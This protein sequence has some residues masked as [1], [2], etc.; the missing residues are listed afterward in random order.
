MAW[1]T[2]Q[3]GADVQGTSRQE[4]MRRGCTQAW[5]ADGSNNVL[6]RKLLSSV[7]GEK[8]YWHN[9]SPH[10]RVGACCCSFL[11]WRL[12]SA[13][14]MQRSDGQHRL[15]LGQP[16]DLL[17]LKSLTSLLSGHT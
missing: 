13:L 9:A 15:L 5:P 7:R 3:Q 16:T 6:Y 4:L 1:V 12:A 14:H 8:I 17:I 11:G 10:R 2:A